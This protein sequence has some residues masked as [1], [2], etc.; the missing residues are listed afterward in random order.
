MGEPT[1]F[2][3][4]IRGRA[5]PQG[6]KRRGDRGQSFE[7]NPRLPGWRRQMKKHLDLQLAGYILPLFDVPVRVTMI[8]DLPWTAAA[9]K[10]GDRW[11]ANQPDLSKLARA[12]EDSCTDARVWTDDRLVVE[13]VRLA[14]RYG[15]DPG[16]YLWI[17]PAS[18]PGVG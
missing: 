9:R 1:I 18:A 3:T 15:D 11:Y 14:K 12:V 6:S 5:R 16:V 10:R 2:S 17:C 8:F 7:A 4:F 13:Y